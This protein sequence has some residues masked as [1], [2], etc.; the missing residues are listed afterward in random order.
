MSCNQ[1]HM[2]TKFNYSYFF[3]WTHQVVFR[4]V[5]SCIQIGKGYGTSY[6]LYVAYFVYPKV[7]KT[8]NLIN[9]SKK[10]ISISLDLMQHSFC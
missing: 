10:S 3:N 6:A 1:N 2:H 9:L 4:L 8:H 7:D 5:T